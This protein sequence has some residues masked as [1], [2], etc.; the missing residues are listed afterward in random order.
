[1]THLYFIRHGDSIED[2]QDGTYQDLGLSPE[3]IEQIEGLRDRL[4]RTGEIKADTL[5]ASPL[6][7]AQESAQILAPALGLQV[8]LDEG[9][10]EWV[11]DD[12]RLSPEEFSA[13]W[14]QVP[15]A[16]RPFTRWMEG[17]ETRLEF[18]VRVQQALHRLAQ[19]YDGKTLVLITHGGV[20]QASFSHFFGLNDANTPGV[21]TENASITH[22]SK[23][24]GGQ[25]WILRRFNDAHHA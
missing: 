18:A 20:I 23:P 11:C 25:K 9:L 14:Q 17:Y 2:L 8:V 1:L 19:E 10:K 3:G 22:W 5:I 6:R 21:A 16:D 7:R 13:R 24:D 4:A 12:G 15:E